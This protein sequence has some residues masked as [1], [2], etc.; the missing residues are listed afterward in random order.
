LRSPFAIAANARLRAVAHPS[1]FLLP[2]PYF[3][4][5]GKQTGQQGNTPTFVT[6]ERYNNRLAWI[7]ATPLVA[8]TPPYF[9]RANLHFEALQA[10]MSSHKSN[11]KT[12]SQRKS[13]FCYVLLAEQL[14]PFGEPVGCRRRRATLGLKT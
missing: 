14:Q 3:R 9:D 7:F 10:S 1:I 6:F 5:P 4:D 8:K 11:A 12:T 13:P 2:T